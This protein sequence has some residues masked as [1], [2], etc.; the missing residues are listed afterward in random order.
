[1]RAAGGLLLAQDEAS[2]RVY[3]MPRAAVEAGA[4]PLSPARLAA[5]LRAVARRAR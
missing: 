5:E 1:V 3:G 2:S 4:R